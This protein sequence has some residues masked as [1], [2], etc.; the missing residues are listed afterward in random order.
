[1]SAP[2]PKRKPAPA[3]KAPPKKAAPPAKKAP[4]VAGKK[5]PPAAVKKKAPPAGRSGSNLAHSL[6]G[7]SYGE[8]WVYCPASL[9]M[10]IGAPDDGDNG[11]SVDGTGMHAVA[12]LCGNQFLTGGAK[13]HPKDYIGVNVLR[14]A[15]KNGK[16]TM[17]GDYVFTK[18]HADLITPYVDYIKEMSARAFRVWLEKRIPLNET[19][20]IPIEEAPIF[21]TGDLS[22]LERNDDGEDTYTLLMDDL[23][24][25]RNKVT[26]KG[27]RKSGNTQLLMY[28]LGLLDELSAEFNITRVRLT[29]HGPRM[30]LADGLDSFEL[31]VDSLGSFRTLARKAA[32][33]ALDLYKAG[34]SKLKLSDFSPNESSC[35]WCKGRENC[36]ARTKWMASELSSAML[37]DEPLPA[38]AVKQGQHGIELTPEYIAAEYAKIPA[39]KAHIATI[40]AAMSRLMFQGDGAP[41]YKLVSVGGGNRAITNESKVISILRGYRLTD[42]DLYTR[43]LKSPAQIEALLVEKGK[44]AAL[45]EVAEY[46]Q[47]P[48]DKPAIAP[49]DDTRPLWQTVDKKDLSLD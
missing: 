45:K 5:A 46:F 21:G 34:K 38:G 40:E 48:E 8:T 6:L 31:P 27:Y 17:Q 15:G 11:A 28:S 25:G 7:P 3:K 30:G 33:K 39:I 42:N 44:D 49:S 1:M 43:K 22:G 20:G 47:K 35:K 18:D 29:I 19:L 37:D 41:G 32:R 14:D 16:G 24:T 2:A 26:A 10:G 12:E 36:G 4:P 23:K 13:H 9:A